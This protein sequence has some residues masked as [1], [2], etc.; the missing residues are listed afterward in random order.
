MKIAYITDTHWRA[1]TPRCR[2]DKN[3]LQQ[4]LDD[5]EF[6]LKTCKENEVELILHCGDVFD[7]FEV[8]FS[9]VNRFADLINKYNIDHICAL[10]Q[11]DCQSRNIHTWKEQSALGVLYRACECLTV[12]EEQSVCRK[13]CNIEENTLLQIEAFNYDSPKTKEGLS[14]KQ[15]TMQNVESSFN[16]A[17][18]HA[19]ISKKDDTL[20]GQYNVESFK[21][22]N[23]DLS[24]FGDIHNFVHS[25]PDK[26][27]TGAWTR[28]SIEDINRKAFFYILEVQ[29]KT[30][31]SKQKVFNP[32]N[33]PFK[34]IKVK[35]T[36]SGKNLSS[37]LQQ[38]KKLKHKSPAERLKEIAKKA[39]VKESITKAAI[40]RLQK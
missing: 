39:N 10:G 34:E 32:H 29:D 1:Q 5:Y 18:F 28:K 33:P 26:L 16:I 19:P 38:A 24:L 6:F 9:C 3:Y 25:S 13:S 15:F 21:Y 12:L 36:I 23:I 2:L 37:L 35:D 20:K 22:G 30:I 17:L 7:H 27:A 11:H 8:S 31:I 4:C 14:K 40:E